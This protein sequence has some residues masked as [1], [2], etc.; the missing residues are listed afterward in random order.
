MSEANNNQ[1]LTALR[2][3][4]AVYATAFFSLSL[5][6]MTSLIVP[7]WALSLGAGPALIG[8]AVAARSVLPLFLSIHGGALMDRLGTRRLMLIF[9]A[10][11]AAVSVLYPL[12]PYVGAL[13][14]LQLLL[15]WAQGMGWIGAQT[16]IARLTRGHPTYAARFSFITAVGTFVGPLLAGVAWDLLGPWGAFGVIALWG[17]SLCLATYQLPAPAPEQ[18][19][20]RGVRLREILPRPSDY[21]RAFALLGNA[22]V[23]LVIVATFLRISA[24][25]VQSSFYPVYLDSIGISGTLIGVLIGFASLIGAPAALLTA[26]ALRA[27]RA[28]WLLL[29]SIGIGIAFIC[30][31]P[32]LDGFLPLLIAAAI[33]G[34]ALGMGLPLLIS[35]MAEATNEREQGVSVGLRTTANRF[36]STVVPVLMGLIVEIVGMALGFLVVG[37]VLLGALGA[38][39]WLAW[40]SPA[41]AR[42]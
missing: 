4:Y 21:V 9:T 18:D 3:L 33:Y 11:A 34:T 2:G 36:A 38:A 28:H 25:G 40:R 10:A 6:P 42:R 14:V 32:L 19:R 35:V 41:F 30:L 27:I 24:F 26:P 29:G 5:V 31:T 37:A 16:K 7:L 23:A 22:G 39:A 8:V 13:I 1:G 15:G 17:A 12:L 20:F